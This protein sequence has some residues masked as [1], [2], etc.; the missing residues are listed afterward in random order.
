MIATAITEHAIMG[1]ISQPPAFT[2][3][4]TLAPSFVELCHHQPL[5]I[6]LYL[7]PQPNTEAHHSRQF[8]TWR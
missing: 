3:S 4:S 8:H 1:S 6:I 7:Q 2:S 5:P